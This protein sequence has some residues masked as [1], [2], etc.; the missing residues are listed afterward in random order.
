M[1]YIFF[2]IL[3]DNSGEKS[4]K[5]LQQKSNPSLAMPSNESTSTDQ[6]RLIPSNHCCVGDFVALRLV[7][8]EHEIPQIGKVLKVDDMNVTIEWWI[9]GYNKTWICW[10]KEKGESVTETVP[11]N[12]VIHK[13]TFTKSM[14]IS[15]NLKADLI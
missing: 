5:K 13:I 15:S 10:K 6:P 14:R 11:K 2:A 8:Y 12:A 9:G 3:T 4:N 1:F 7:K